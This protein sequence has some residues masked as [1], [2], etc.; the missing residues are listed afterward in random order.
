MTDEVFREAR[1][2]FEFLPGVSTMRRS[3]AIL[4][5]GGVKER[6]IRNWCRAVAEQYGVEDYVGPA[7]DQNVM[8]VGLKLAQA[9]GQS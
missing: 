7:F 4:A 8:A 1:Q 5:R 2:A 3:I 9:E 6:Q